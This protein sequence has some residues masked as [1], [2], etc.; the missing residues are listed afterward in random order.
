[1]DNLYF[2]IAELV[3]KYLADDLTDAERVRLEEWVALSPENR[4]WFRATTAQG[5]VG[6]KRNELCAI[7]VKAG[8]NT[9]T[10]KREKGRKRRLWGNGLKCACV[11]VPL[12]LATLIYMMTKTDEPGYIPVAKQEILPGMRKAV[13][14]MADGSS[15]ELGMQQGKTLQEQDGTMIGLQGESITYENMDSVTVKKQLY[16][17]LVVPRGGEYVLTLSDGTVVHLN[18]DSKLRF[19]VTFT[20]DT[21]TVELMGEGYFRVARNEKVPFIVKTSDMAVTVLGTE[22][23]VSSY[24]NQK[25]VQTTLVEGVVKITSPKYDG[26]YILE[27]GEQAMFDKEDGRVVVR[28]VD[29]SYAVAWKDGY[30]RFRDKPLREVMEII[31]R[32]YDVEVVYKDEEVKDYLFGG[33]FDR[34]TTVL[35]LLDILQGTGTVHFEVRGKEIVVSK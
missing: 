27:P 1:M 12:A 33:N 15:V 30:L 5:N 11:I 20:G 26:S 13:L 35:P 18:A 7:D 25:E 3:S 10:R 4:E 16:N 22:F 34:H 29:V 6:K 14:L 28:E 8:W 32:W 9:L 21:R 24:S 17:E 19:P 23:N 2:E 31:A